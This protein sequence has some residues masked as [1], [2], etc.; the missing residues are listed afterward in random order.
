MILALIGNVVFAWSNNESM[1]IYVLM[2]LMETDDVSAAIVFATLNT[3][4]ARLDLVHRLAM[5][6]IEDPETARVL[7]DLVERF[8]AATRLRNE[9]NHS[10]YT[11]DDKGEITH[12]SSTRV[13]ESRRGG[14]Q[15]GMSRAMNDER[16]REIVAAIE[17]MR[18]LNRDLWAFL[19]RLEA[20]VAARTARMGRQAAPP[21]S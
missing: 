13:H 21:R 16:V 12:T 5:V 8:N 2:L 3:T 19:P 10:M 7:D 9:F 15:L 6:K 14:L 11:L 20:A 1:F 17:D 18:S 4:R